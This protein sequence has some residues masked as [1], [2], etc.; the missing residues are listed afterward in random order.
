MSAFMEGLCHH[1]FAERPRLGMP[2]LGA[3][4]AIVEGHRLAG[5]DEVNFFLN[6]LDVVQVFNRLMKDWRNLGVDIEQTQFLLSSIF[7]FFVAASDLNGVTNRQCFE[8]RV[9]RFL[10]RKQKELP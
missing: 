8:K 1:R 6:T 9:N 2:V 7:V 4:I 3:S 5:R 10:K